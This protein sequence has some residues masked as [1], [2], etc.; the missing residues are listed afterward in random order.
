MGNGPER[1]WT[2]TGGY[3]EGEAGY[4]RSV[5]VGDHIWVSGCTAT[6]V[7]GEPITDPAEQTHGTIDQIARSLERLGSG[8]EDV[9][10]TR[11]WISSLEDLEP[12][13][14]AHGERF[15]DIRPAN[16]LAQVGLSSGILVE[17]EA[18]AMVG[19]GSNST[20]VEEN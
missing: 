13:A 11:I 7:D 14:K 5:R 17:I 16:F 12:I 15:R 8:L 18:E 1:Q 2:T 6:E 20:L 4:A 10:Q 3:W 19:S 9:V